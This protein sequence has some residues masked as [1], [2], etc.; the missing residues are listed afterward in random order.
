MTRVCVL[1]TGIMGGH[2]ARRLHAAGL[3]VTVWNRTRGKA[4]ATALR[5]AD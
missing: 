3:D 4:A 5:L 1:G 2:M